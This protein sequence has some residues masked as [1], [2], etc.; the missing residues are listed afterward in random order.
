MKQ[1]LWR[2]TLWILIAVVIVGV[3]YSIFKVL[4]YPPPNE[5]TIATGREGS[6]SY[7]FAVLYQERLAELDYSLNIHPTAGSDATLALL[8]A[9]KVDAG[10]V[11]GVTSA[12]DDTAKLESLASL[13]YMPLW[14]FYRADL[15]DLASNVRDLEGATI[16]IGEIGSGTNRSARF[17]LKENGIS[18]DNS[19]LL[20]IADQEAARRLMAGEI[21]V[22][23]LLASPKS[24]VVAQLLQEPNI[25]VLNNRRSLA[26][27]SRYNNIKILTLG[28]GAIDLAQNIPSE[29]KELIAT[30]GTLVANK[31]L[32]P[33]LARL[34]LIVAA[35]VHKEGGLFEDRDEFPSA[36]LVSI[37]LN[38]DAENFLE[39]G[40][41]GL[42]QYMPLWIAS[43]IERI[44]FIAIPAL[45]LFYPF[46]RGTPLVF[47]FF[48]RYR[49]YRWYQYVRN[50]ELGIDEYDLDTIGFKTAELDALQKELTQGMRVPVM[51]LQ[52]FYNLRL[53]I[54]LVIGR[55]NRQKE[56][57][58]YGNQEPLD[59]KT[60]VLSEDE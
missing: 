42:D 25:E 51:Y 47:A 9:G 33:D 53:H 32:H 6:D 20:P 49:I 23:M 37:P 13:F 43:R 55:L 41:T 11:V 14:A 38:Q 15:V 54:D 2:V 7:N 4:S 16:A 31:D 5:F 56:L 34:L 24:D 48:F 17:I 60:A 1:K 29:D 58:Q 52:D 3:I 21:D 18:E 8:A 46:F 26:Y 59:E 10:F 28:E 45:I 19:T 35:G 40:S 12:S 36:K 30:V 39:N 27:E 22:M 57:L 50:I 44:L